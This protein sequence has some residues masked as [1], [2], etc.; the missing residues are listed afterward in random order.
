MVSL[1]TH[2]EEHLQDS[3]FADTWQAAEAARFLKDEEQAAIAER[4]DEHAKW[5]AAG[6]PRAEDV[7]EDTEEDNSPF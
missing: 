5:V 2:Y 1:M 6:C 7:A 3:A 4:A